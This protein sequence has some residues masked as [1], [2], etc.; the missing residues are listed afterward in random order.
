MRNKI[1]LTL[2]VLTISLPAFASAYWIDVKGSGKVNEPVTIELCYG[3]MD[4]QGVRHRDT[5]KELLLTGD[6]HFT[7]ID[8]KGSKQELHF[9]M[10]QDHWLAVYV[11]QQE[12]QYRIVGFNDKHPVIDRSANG[13]KNVLPIDY[14]TAVYTVGNTITSAVNPLQK[15][16]L[17]VLNQDGKIT[18]K[19]FL[20]D[21]PSKSGTKLRV[22]NPENWEK[23]LTLDAN[24]EAVFYPTMKGL[25]ILRQDWIEPASGTYQNITYSSKRHRC[26][27][28]LLW[29]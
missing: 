27:Y 2:F 3:S 4:E 8:S 21:K 12:G 9:K 16:D 6:F 25:Y 13:G 18:V 20:D 24:G 23:E 29:K 22:F 11:P 1:L 17:I 26:N 19:A 10:Q 15:L 28:F 14:I 5:T 7:I